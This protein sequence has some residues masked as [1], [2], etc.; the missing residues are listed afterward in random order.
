MIV[1]CRGKLLLKE[2]VKVYRAKF[3]YATGVLGDQLA[4][5]DVVKETVQLQA[6]QGGVPFEASVMATKTLFLPC[7]IYNWTPPEGAGQFHGMP[8]EVKVRNSSP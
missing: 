2:V 3:R 7:A 8:T 5:A 6:F 4:I 1:V